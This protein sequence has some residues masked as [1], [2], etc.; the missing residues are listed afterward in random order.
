MFP[1]MRSDPRNA[2]DSSTRPLS[3][4]KQRRARLGGGRDT[5]VSGVP[6][7]VRRLW[8]LQHVNVGRRVQVLVVDDRPRVPAVRHTDGRGRA[9][10]ARLTHRPHA[11]AGGGRPA[12]HGP[13]H[14]QERRQSP[15]VTAGGAT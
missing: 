1:G 5:Y 6:G 12:S 14:R 4:R 8:A 3:M 10:D 15:T 7:G 9:S 2:R 13:H 11:V